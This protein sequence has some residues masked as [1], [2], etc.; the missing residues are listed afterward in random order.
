MKL[1]GVF[2]RRMTALCVAVAALL[3]VM[4]LATFAR[5]AAGP[6]EVPLREQ[7]LE[8]AVSGFAPGWRV[9]ANGA[10]LDIF[11]SDGLSG[12]RLRDVTVYDAQG[13]E[14]AGAPLLALR[15][16]W[17]TSGTDSVAVREVAVSGMA[18]EVT[19]LEDGSFH[20]GIG[21]DGSSTAL[22]DLF[23]GTDAATAATVPRLR[24]RDA[25]LRYRDLKRGVEITAVDGMVLLD[26]E[27]DGLRLELDAGFRRPAGEMAKIKVNLTRKNADNTVAGS[28]VFGGLVPSELAELDPALDNL[29][30]IR[31][32]LSGDLSF[33][34]DSEGVPSLVSGR[35]AAQPGGQIVIA[36]TVR[37]FSRLSASLG[38]DAAT[39]RLDLDDL[40]VSSQ[41]LDL[42][43]RARLTLGPSG[44]ISAALDFPAFSWRPEGSEGHLSLHD[45]KARLEMAPQF[46]SVDLAF[47]S[48]TD[49]HFTD[50][51]GRVTLSTLEVQGR[52]SKADGRIT[53]RDVAANGLSLQ[54][55]DD[56][57]RA[58]ATSL[59]G[60]ASYD[61]ASQNL[62]FPQLALA[63]FKAQTP[64]AE[65]RIG[66]LIA[67]GSYD[68]P[69]GLLTINDG[70]LEAVAA[71]LPDGTALDMRSARLSLRAE[72]AS[73]AFETERLNL[74]DLT[75][76]LPS[77]FDAPLRA[78]SVAARL[79]GRGEA[80]GYR[81]RA[82]DLSGE[83]EGLAAALKADV[84]FRKGGSVTGRLESALGPVPSSRVAELWPKGVAPGA[85]RWIS[86]NIRSGTIP[87]ATIETVFDT[88]APKTSA[89]NL[90]FNFENA[91]VG[92]SGDLPPLVEARGTARVTLH[93]LNVSL[94]SGAVDVPGAGRFALKKSSFTIPEFKAKP[95]IGYL[96]LDVAGAA[97]PILHF[98]DTKPLGFISKSGFDIATAKAQV[99]GKVQVSLPLMTNMQI[100]D[101]GYNARAELHEFKFF[102]PHTALPIEGDVLRVTVLEEG[103]ELKGD[104]RIDGLSARLTYKQR[105]SA[106]AQGQP[107]SSLRFESFLTPEDFARRGFDPGD[108]FKG[109]AA[110]EA[111]ANL[112][113][114]GGGRFRIEADM[115][116]AVLDVESLG[117]SKPDGIPVTILAEGY[118]NP[119]GAGSIERLLIDGAVKGSGKIS[120]AQSGAIDAEF[121]QLI[122]GDRF[123]AGIRYQRGPEGASRVE[124]EGPLADIR[125]AFAKAVDS[126]SATRVAPPK[127]GGPLMEVALKIG[128]ARLRDDLAVT[129][130]SGGFR[131]RGDTV[132]AA[133]IIGKANARAPFELLAERREDGL[134]LRLTSQDAGSFL[135]AASIFS[136]AYGGKLRLDARTRDTVL[137]TQVAGNIRI[138]GI[139]VRD[140]ATLRKILSGGS[141]GSL[142]QQMTAGGIAFSKVALPFAGVGGRWQIDNGIAYG[143]AV[144]LTLTGGYDIA[145]KGIDLRGTVSPAY[146]INGALGAVPLLG[147]FLTGG[148]GEGVFGVTFSVSG[149]TDRPN[150]WVNPLSAIAPGFLRKIVSG[151]MDGQQAAP[152]TRS[153][154]EE[155]LRDRER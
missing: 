118:R 62:S 149:T 85:L 23:V 29:S 87:N 140:S 83:I 48:G 19:R 39:K 11:G 44:P 36:D 122:L 16:A 72:T 60:T 69:S 86:K 79:S 21:E 124:I 17:D 126:S 9:D 56:A 64:E 50:P 113:P 90:D 125:T 31:A 34:L 24:I 139:E 63:E 38:Y 82:S 92:I 71:A 5:L 144:G 42:E 61:L 33:A 13:Q 89:M 84:L 27:G 129:D 74:T 10:D 53:L 12:I 96:D 1:V 57:I 26:P 66:A 97:T 59:R 146:A 99:R 76:A 154:L 3:L 88:A 109:V 131:L 116:G 121:A 112:F 145:R 28:A 94:D 47:L 70:T 52:Y 151:V 7:L 95:P 132:H 49:L 143:P 22:S 106:P 78:A 111:H 68:A 98:L 104:A 142:V 102:E 93:D 51:A 37:Q 77:R 4:V 35:I 32:E 103:L 123:D 115:T 15:L 25:R 30:A 133:K 18:V 150:V 128:A 130:L 8:R 75:V 148:E 137:P 55:R 20:L 147:A 91:V 67:S 40:D 108:Y 80:E 135:G 114:G 73:G 117:W 138:D 6:I 105:F 100:T 101:V 107:E 41:G 54:P 136:G 141:I 155:R 2:F 43:G 119:D 46:A 14:V 127:R 152:E 110:V 81:L 65:A 153:N 120:Y 134:A 58:S 45:L